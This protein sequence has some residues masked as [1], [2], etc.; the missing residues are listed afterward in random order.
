ML[1]WH[2]PLAFL[3]LFVLAALAVFWFL[4][5]HKK[6][7]S[8]QIGSLAFLKRVTK[9]TL[10]LKLN[11]LPEFLKILAMVFMV[12]A[13]A[14]PQWTEEKIK[15]NINGIDI[16]IALDISDSML[17]EDMEPLNRLEAA[18]KTISN[19][20][21]GRVSDRIGLVLFM[22]EA[23]T[24]VPLT[25]DYPLILDVVKD[26]EPSRSVKMGTAIGV[27]LA[28][29][30]ARLKD[31]TAKSRVV[32]LLTDGENN[33]GT[34]DPETALEIAKG[35]GIKVY[36]IGIGRDGETKIPTYS[37]DPFGNKVKRYQPFYSTVNEDLL[38]RYAKE[39]GG[40]YWRA[41]TSESLSDTFKKID[42]LEKTKIEVNKYTRY[43]EKFLKFVLGA[44]A[45]YLLALVLQATWFRR[46][47]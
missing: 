17:I 1:T 36:T 32:I 13:L 19:F 12:I 41:N 9:K 44:L 39:T 18:K 6:I 29:S 8:L 24:K 16:V 35:Y 45:L 14:R 20:I 34:I 31:S 47:P 28:N 30:V 23:F 43:N 38:K 7:A 11:F 10:S 21:Q 42:Q 26:V 22:G 4:N 37:V 15:K 33:S 3:F 2:S 27:A 25:L 5:R 40:V 46:L